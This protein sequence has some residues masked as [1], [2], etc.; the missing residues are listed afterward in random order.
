MFH[1][2]AFEL[3]ENG[4][5]F[6]AEPAKNLVVGQDGLLK[7]SPGAAEGELVSRMIDLGEGNHLRF[8]GWVASTTPK[9]SVKV[10]YRGSEKAPWQEAR[11]SSLIPAGS[12]RFLQ[13][14][15]RISRQEPAREPFLRELFISTKTLAEKFSEAKLERK[16]IP[17]LA[18]MML[19][20]VTPEKLYHVYSQLPYDASERG[21]YILRNAPDKT[22]GEDY[23]FLPDGNEMY[24]P[25]RYGTR[26]LGRFH[27]VATFSALSLRPKDVILRSKD[28]KQ[29]KAGLREQ[30][31]TVNFF[32]K[33]FLKEYRTGLRAAVRYYKENNPYLFGYTLMCPEFFYDTEPW[34][35]MTFLSGFSPEALAAYKEFAAKLERPAEAWPAPS[36][37]DILLDADS[38]LWAYWRSRAGA[39]YI[40]SLARIIK[41][42]NPAARV[43]TMHYVGAQ[44][45]RGLE[46][47]F[48]ELN[49]DFD[50]YYSS[51]LYPRVP[52]K[53]GLDGGTVFSRTRLNVEGHSR[54]RNV[55]EYDIWSPYVDAKRALTYARYAALEGVET[56]PIVL[57]DFPDNKP[58]NHL[59]RYHG[60]K[61][62]PVTPELLGELA[63]HMREVKPLRTSKKFSQ[64]AVVLPSISLHALLE[65]DRWLPHRLT[66]QEL[67]VLKPLLELNVAFDFLT[68]GYVT[69]E[70]LDN[71]KLVIVSQAAIYPWM[72]KAL[73]ETKADILAL[74][75]AGSVSA[76]GPARLLAPIEPEQFDF[77][78]THGWPRESA[79][80]GK[81][82]FGGELYEDTTIFNFSDNRHAL[83]DGLRGITLLYSAP[84]LQGKPLPYAAGMKG[85]VLV[86]DVKGNPVYT[87][88]EKE[89]KIIC[90]GGLPWQLTADGGEKQFFTPEQ[91]K[92]FFR[93]IMAYCG[94]EHYPESGALRLMRNRDF[95]L[96]EN[97][98]EQPFKGTLPKAANPARKLP[99]TALEIP[100]LG[101]VVIPLR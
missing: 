63:E 96:V 6:S 90:F 101:S 60:M 35:Q 39:D 24:L 54:K 67:H 74:G 71:Y 3:L 87:V 28:G 14:R 19:Y 5:S 22:I 15:I 57:G 68:E 7:L 81:T 75:W 26:I 48:V 86:T 82:F 99:E 56:T 85:E 50:F 36:D 46:P 84:G 51:N 33:E 13:Y 97:T 76:P 80:K 9:T 27:P 61:G 2:M 70:L 78:L 88:E 58:S 69:K 11:N 12:G 8:L 93:N 95:L 25:M 21:L 4:K 31:R 23:R 66:Q 18:M 55:L 17:D 73:E 94:I 49:P 32:D 16:D 72:R 47:G 62:S 79:G 92:R 65:K 64:V 20:S 91:E 41:E 37:G 83:L 1:A 53:D 45:L 29:E 10:D 38:Y 44:S 42:E 98:S 40:A 100:A 43:G 77:T 59:T 89:R 30:H 52:G 34:P